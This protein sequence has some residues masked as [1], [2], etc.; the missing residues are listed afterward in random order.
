MGYQGDGGMLMRGGPQHQAGGGGGGPGRAAYMQQQPQRP[1][2]IP[3]A[4]QH[5]QAPLYGAGVGRGGAGPM[6]LAAHPD[7]D[8]GF[9][10][11]HHHQGGRVSCGAGH[12]W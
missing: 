4:S 8:G 11:S 12:F 2:A 3:A 7:G 1:H 10:P 9:P 6:Y 5:H